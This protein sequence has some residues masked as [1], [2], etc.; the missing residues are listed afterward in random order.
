MRT[1]IELPDKLLARAKSQAALQKISLKKFFIQAIECRLAPQNTKVR[2][3]A[4]TIGN[5]KALS[6]TVL[7]PEQV[8]E[9]IF[10]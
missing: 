7:T 8:D 3:P 5:T 6:I 2:R 10:G 4:P 1:T 9:E